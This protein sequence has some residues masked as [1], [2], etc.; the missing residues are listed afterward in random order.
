VVVGNLTQFTLQHY[1]DGAKY[2]EGIKKNLFKDLPRLKTLLNK[3]SKTS[4]D[5]SVLKSVDLR[6]Y[7]LVEGTQA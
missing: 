5:V 4:E 7:L 3:S 6:N 2:S 1:L